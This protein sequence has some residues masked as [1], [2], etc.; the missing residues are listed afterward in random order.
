[1][2]TEEGVSQTSIECLVEMDM[3]VNVMKRCWDRVQEL[4]VKDTVPAT[5]GYRIFTGIGPDLLETVGTPS[6]MPFPT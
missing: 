4:I 3:R 6:A 1:M 5:E 2:Q